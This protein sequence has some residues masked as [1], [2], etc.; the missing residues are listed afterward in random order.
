MKLKILSTTRSDWVL[1]GLAFLAERVYKAR[2][3]IYEDAALSKT[4][5]LQIFCASMVWMGICVF[6][7]QPMCMGLRHSGHDNPSDKSSVIC[8][9][10]KKISEY[11]RLFQDLI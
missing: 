2:I 4:L 10:S 9:S 8:T 3:R 6:G 5:L 7:Y 11:F 1:P